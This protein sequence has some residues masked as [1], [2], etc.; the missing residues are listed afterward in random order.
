MVGVEVAAALIGVDI[1]VR[2][3][4]DRAIINSPRFRARAAKT[5]RC[6]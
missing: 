3:Y 1:A 6:I 4:R 2:T 5:A